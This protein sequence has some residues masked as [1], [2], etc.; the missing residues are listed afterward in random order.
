[1][2]SYLSDNLTTS[3]CEWLLFY[4]PNI[5]QNAPNFICIISGALLVGVQ[6]VHQGC[7]FRR[8]RCINLYIFAQKRDVQ[9]VCVLMPVFC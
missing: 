9:I 4:I 8:V 2:G 1:M 3:S 7:P 6:P 5:G